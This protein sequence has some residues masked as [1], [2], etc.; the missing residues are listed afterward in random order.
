MRLQ[1]L[2]IN[3]SVVVFV[4]LLHV[5]INEYNFNILYVNLMKRQIFQVGKKNRE[6]LC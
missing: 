3:V 1:A 4:N 5:R 2:M 6:N